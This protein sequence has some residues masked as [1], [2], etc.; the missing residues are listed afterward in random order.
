MQSS[1]S[2]LVRKLTGKPAFLTIA[3]CES[4]ARRIQNQAAMSLSATVN[5]A[6]RSHSDF[7]ALAR[8]IA[9]VI[10]WLS[11]GESRACIRIPRSLDFGTFG[12]PSLAFINTLRMTKIVVD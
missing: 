11:S 3:D 1:P 2:L 9:A 12:L 4:E 7:D 8:R 5:N 10:F 6:L